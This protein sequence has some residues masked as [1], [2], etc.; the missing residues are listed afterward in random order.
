MESQCILQYVHSL[1]VLP[2]HEAGVTAVGVSEDGMKILAATA[3][4]IFRNHNYKKQNIFS[5]LLNFHKWVFLITL[6]ENLGIFEI[7]DILP[8]MWSVMCVGKYRSAG[9]WKSQLCHSNEVTHPA[10]GR[11][12]SGWAWPIPVDLFP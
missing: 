12:M 7:T 4:V 9:C 5:E 1:N 6:C 11:G 10:S 8:S 2:E 3:S